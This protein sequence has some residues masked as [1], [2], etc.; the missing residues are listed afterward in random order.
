M[1]ISFSITHGNQKID[2]PGA[3]IGRK[4]TQKTRNKI[5]TNVESYFSTNLGFNYDK[6]ISLIVKVEDGITKSLAKCEFDATLYYKIN[7]KH[8]YKSYRDYVMVAE[9]L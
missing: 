8:Y 2:I 4:I 5:K 9:K 6:L 7:D 3:F 1:S